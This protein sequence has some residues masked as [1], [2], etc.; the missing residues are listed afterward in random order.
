MFR[1]VSVSPQYVPEAGVLPDENCMFVE[2]NSRFQEQQSG[3]HSILLRENVWTNDIGEH[4]GWGRRTSENYNEQGGIL[5]G[6][7]FFDEKATQQI[8]GIVEKAVPAR[9][10]EGSPA[11]LSMNH[12]SWHEM[13]AEMDGMNDDADPEKKLQVIGWYHTHPNELSVFMSGTDRRTQ[14]LFFPHDWQFAIV[15]NP[16]RKYWKAFYGAQAIECPG[17]IIK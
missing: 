2:F 16:H 4:I 5:L 13:L 15:L 3:D 10:A 6:R 11:Y 8:F 14:R 9:A 7:V 12:Q 1:I 17:F